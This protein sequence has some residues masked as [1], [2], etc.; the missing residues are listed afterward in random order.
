MSV[1]FSSGAGAGQTFS[2]KGLRVSC[3]ARVWLLLEGRGRLVGRSSWSWHSECT[4]SLNLLFDW[5]SRPRL[6]LEYFSEIA[7]AYN[8]IYQCS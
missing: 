1:L 2:E 4:R 7:F 5:Y 3:L 6:L 8:K